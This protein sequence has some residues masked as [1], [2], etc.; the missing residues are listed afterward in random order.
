MI[1]NFFVSLF[2]VFN[3]LSLNESE[4]APSLNRI[5]S[6]KD[7]IALTKTHSLE[8]SKINQQLDLDELNAESLMSLYRWRLTG[9]LNSSDGESAPTSP[10]SPIGQ[11]ESLNANVR[12]EKETALGI[13]PY[14]S[15]S[16][17]SRQSTLPT[18]PTP[19]NVE[20]KLASVEAGARFNIMNLVFLKNSKFIFSEYDL[21]R[22]I[23]QVSKEIAE[24]SLEK[25]ILLSHFD[26]IKAK[27]IRDVLNIQCSQYKKLRGITSSRYQKKLIREKDYLLVEVLYKQCLV[28]LESAR[29]NYRL[30]IESLKKSSGLFNFRISYKNVSYPNI[31]PIMNLNT[32]SNND[33]VL[34][35]LL[36]QASESSLKA[37]QYRKLPELNL[38]LGLRSEASDTTSD[39][40]YSE[41]FNESLKG[42]RLTTDIGLTFSHSF[43]DS[44]Q[45]IAVD[46]TLIQSKIDKTNL[47]LLRQ[48]LKRDVVRVG[49]NLSHFDSLLRQVN[50]I[51]NLQKRKS[52]VF[53]KDFQNGRVAIRELVEAE[54]AYLLSLQNSLNVKDLRMRAYLEAHDLS[55]ASFEKFY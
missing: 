49:L 17:D 2:F 47:E 52:R 27:K 33:V 40:S 53:N 34:S 13:T 21:R 3:A 29:N 15:L 45:D 31:T 7:I 32:S 50:E 36:F 44:D 10:F 22:K 12:L 28:D 23:S 20:Y 4:K 51:E 42:E 25:R 8:F 5:D 35:E 38:T 6:G 39:S 11:S 14:V 18:Q 24:R 43:G 48:S 16:T 9:T 46:R 1:L 41:V 30:S 26:V 37:T 19:S 54:V 55:G